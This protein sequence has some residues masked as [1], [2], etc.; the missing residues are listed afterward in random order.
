MQKITVR[1]TE[2]REIIQANRD[3]HREIFEEAVEAFKARCI[4]ELESRLKDVRAGRKINMMISLPVPE[5]H[6]EDYDRALR[7]LELSIDDEIDLTEEDVAQYVQDDWSWSRAWAAN[8]G[9]Y[10]NSA[11]FAGMNR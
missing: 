3:E 9:S 7:M 6:T 5:D 8:T 4:E 10:S 1:K 11:K 2:L